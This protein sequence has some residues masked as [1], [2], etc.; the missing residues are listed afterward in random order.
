[1]KIVGILFLI[2][3]DLLLASC[4]IDTISVSKLEITIQDAHK[5]KNF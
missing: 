2:T 4:A 1:M 5:R 3:V